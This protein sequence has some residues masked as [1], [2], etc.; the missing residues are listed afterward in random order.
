MS[1]IITTNDL[2]TYMSPKTLLPAVAAQ[3]VDAMNA[4]VETKTN[5]VW[6]ETKD[7]VERL[8]WG[9]T[10]YLRHQDV[11]AISAIK[12]GWPGQTQTTI[13]ASGYF[14]N[15]RGRVTMF[16]QALSRP[17][18]GSPLY[19]DYLEVSY[20]HGV[21]AVPGDLKLATLG[22]AAGFYN[23][24]T[25]GQK[26]VSSAAV[27]SYKLEYGKHLLAGRKPET[28]VADANWTI[29]DSYKMRKS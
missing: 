25:N 17:N 26:D 13:A 23:F 1:Q 15:S 7:V 22:I 18:P 28:I 11:T 29:I 10:L 21:T 3:V 27:G 24:A 12:V 20:T 8:D 4:W 14:F 6:G 19:R 16:W 2:N 9:R 5:R